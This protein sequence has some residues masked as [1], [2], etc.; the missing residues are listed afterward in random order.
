MKNFRN[1]VKRIP[2]AV[3]AVRE[4]R[5]FLASRRA[6]SFQGGDWIY[7]RQ[8]VEWLCNPSMRKQLP[9]LYR[10]FAAYCAYLY[11]LGGER[12]TGAQAFHTALISLR[13]LLRLKEDVPLM[14]GSRTIFVNLSDP[15]MLHV[16][17]EVAADYPDTSILKR[18]IGGGDTFVDVGANH[19]SFAVVASEIVGAAGLVVAVEPQ[20]NLSIL[21]GKSL[22]A[23]ARGK[24]QVH[25]VACGDRSD[26][27]DF[28][29]PKG[30]SG[31]AGLF[32]EF[33]GVPPHR[34]TS[35]PVKR[36]DDFVDWSNF[37]GKT[38]V[39]VDVEGSEMNFLRGADKMIRQL[40]PDMML[41]INPS[42]IEAAGEAHPVMLQHLR[43]LGYQK[44]FEVTPF[45]GPKSLDC[46]DNRRRRNVIV[47]AR[48]AL[49]GIAPA[50][51][52]F[53]PADILSFIP[54][55]LMLA[56]ISSSIA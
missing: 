24:Y 35:V 14:V 51:S 8:V 41:E 44:F 26:T 27:V 28:Y 2:G 19:G 25:N 47:T 6:G 18:F 10:I 22:A 37:P 53:N 48:N 17:N 45:E 31:G 9:P 30:S 32:S 4:L 3:Y 50:V 38:F 49:L 33:S 12:V 40:K 56:G 42:S 15:R 36:F 34:R 54:F 46:L 11:R 29:I 7:E 43:Q 1:F 21:V 20:S 13:K 5:D 16:P 52:S 55:Y 39:K 23:T